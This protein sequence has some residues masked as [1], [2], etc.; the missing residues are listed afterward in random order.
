MSINYAYNEECDLFDPDCASFSYASY[1]QFCATCLF[2]SLLSD[3][4]T[5]VYAIRLANLMVFVN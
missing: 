4:I 1:R 2:D 3:A 5:T